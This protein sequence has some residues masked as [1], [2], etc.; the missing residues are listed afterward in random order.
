MRLQLSNSTD[1]DYKLTALEQ[2][3]ALWKK[4]KEYQ[5]DRLDKLRLQNDNKLDEIETA[6]LRGKI[7]AIKG[8]LTVED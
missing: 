8:F 5:L 6:Y 2:Q 3:S 4:L 7:A 1:K